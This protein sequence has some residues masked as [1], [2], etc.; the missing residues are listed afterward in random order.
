MKIQADS[1]AKAE[2][3]EQILISLGGN[4]FVFTVMT[5]ISASPEVT[6]HANSV[7]TLEFRILFSSS[8]ASLTYMIKKHVQLI[9]KLTGKLRRLYKEKL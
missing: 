3:T 4:W 9:F 1:S 5:E 2:V 7:A 8:P 6:G